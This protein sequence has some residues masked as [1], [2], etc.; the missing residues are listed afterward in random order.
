MMGVEHVHHRVST[1]RKSF[2]GTVEPVATFV[3]VVAVGWLVAVGAEADAFSFQ[4]VS[5]A[6]GD[7][8]VDDVT[9]DNR[10]QFLDQGL[11]IETGHGNN[12]S[13]VNGKND[14]APVWLEKLGE[15]FGSIHTW[16]M[17]TRIG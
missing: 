8:Q 14:G 2:V 16:G 4:G 10:I 3:D 13:V 12:R 17:E 7:S 9:V 1:D 11:R 15:I 6:E 5:S